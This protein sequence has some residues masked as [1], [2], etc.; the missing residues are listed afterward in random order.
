MCPACL[1]SVAVIAAG[2]STAG[3]AAALVLGVTSP[4]FFVVMDS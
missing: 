3:G 2:T 1:A 4:R